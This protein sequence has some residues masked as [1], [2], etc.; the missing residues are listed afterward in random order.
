[1]SLQKLW[2]NSQK[3][4]N[5]ANICVIGITE[6]QKLLEKMLKNPKIGQKIK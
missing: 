5:K 4:S 2:D 6:G 1:M 3:I